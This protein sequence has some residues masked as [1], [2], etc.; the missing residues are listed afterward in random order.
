MVGIII[1]CVYDAGKPSVEVC[2][3]IRI[4]REEAQELAE[5]DVNNIIPTEGNILYGR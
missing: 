5:L 3:K 2:K 4:K 1:M